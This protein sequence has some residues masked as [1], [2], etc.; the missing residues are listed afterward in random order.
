M[1]KEVDAIMEK[2]GNPK[3][4]NWSQDIL[5]DLRHIKAIFDAGGPWEIEYVQAMNAAINAGDDQKLHS[6]A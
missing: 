6:L 4:A 5:T 1:K 3:P 2:I